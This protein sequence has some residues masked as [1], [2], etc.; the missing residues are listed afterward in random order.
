MCELHAQGV[1]GDRE[2]APRERLRRIRSN[3]V[4]RRRRPL[5]A[6]RR[7]CQARAR[8]AFSLGLA[9]RGHN[10][11]APRRRREADENCMPVPSAITTAVAMRMLIVPCLRKANNAA[12][13]SVR[14][15]TAVLICTVLRYCSN[16][17][18]VLTLTASSERRNINTLAMRSEMRHSLDDVWRETAM[19]DAAYGAAQSMRRLQA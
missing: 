2:R 9:K 6:A 3:F 8:L 13:A 7:R 10:D 19:W 18:C 17:R 14:S 1:R 15:R 4:R 11:T 12:H 5:P 16:A